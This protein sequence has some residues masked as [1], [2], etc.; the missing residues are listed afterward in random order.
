M[1]RRILICGGVLFLLGWGTPQASCANSAGSF[2]ARLRRMNP[3]DQIDGVAARIEDDIITESEV[4]ELGAFQQLVDGKPETRDQIIR[5]LADQW[6]IRAEA[7]AAQYAQ[8]SAADVDRAYAE[9]VKQY[10]SAEVFQQKCAAAGLSEAAVRRLVQQQLYLAR[11]IDYRFRPAAQVTD[12]QVAD[13]YRDTFVPQLQARHSEIPLLD[14]V[15][16]TIR[17]V[18]IQRAISDRETKWLDETRGRLKID[19][20]SKDGGS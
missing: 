10:P 19:V 9:F 15:D 20:M 2:V 12:Q 17:E 1:A 8:P 14:D 6:L 7:A 5:E 4:R 18:L 16:D 13:Y 11:F 3:T